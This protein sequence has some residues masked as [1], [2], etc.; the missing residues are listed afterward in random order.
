[1][2]GQAVQKP[3]AYRF[4]P[5][6]TG[7]AAVACCLLL[8]K[9]VV[10]E[11]GQ[12]LR[13]LSKRAAASEADTERERVVELY[14]LYG[15]AIHRRCLRLLG[16][17]DAGNDATQ[18]VFIRLIRNVRNL[19]TRDSAIRWIYRVSINHCLHLIRNAARRSEGPIPAAEEPRT[20]GGMDVVAHRQLVEKVLSRFDKKTQAVALGVLALGMEHEEVADVLGISPTTVARRLRRFSV[21]SRKYLHRTN[22]L[23]AGDESCEIPEPLQKYG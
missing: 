11:G 13:A 3:R 21:N 5:D 9:R 15:P 12:A 23:G 20:S 1:V 10:R 17:K 18:E 16:D 14:K 22:A 4:P 2:P 6:G 7:A 19:E 8:T